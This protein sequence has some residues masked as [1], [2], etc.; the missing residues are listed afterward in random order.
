MNRTDHCIVRIRDVVKEF[1]GETVVNHMNLDIAE[2]EFLTILGP[3]GCGKTTTLRMIAG[4]EDV[5]SGEILLEGAS[6]EGLPPNV[7]NINTVFQN[8][9]LFPHMTVEDNIAFGL[10][11]K[12]VPKDK[13]KEKVSE[14][15]KLVQL[16]GLEKRKPSQLSGGQ[17]QR[18]STSPR[19]CFWT[20]LWGLWISNSASRCRRN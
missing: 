18:V 19:C 2:G 5:T 1:D 9:A 11:E 12:K 7:R 6:V 15:V 13:I 14:A 10:V 16:E 3:S 4:F 20:S 17:R 8:Y